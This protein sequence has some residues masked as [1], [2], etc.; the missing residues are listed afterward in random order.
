MINR[1]PRWLLATVV[2]AFS[3]GCTFTDLLGPGMKRPSD[4]P[5]HSKTEPD[6]VDPAP[7]TAQTSND[8]GKPRTASRRQQ[9]MPSPPPMPRRRSSA[10]RIA[11]AGVPPAT[12]SEVTASGPD[13]VLPRAGEGGSKSS[14]GTSMESADEEPSTTDSPLPDVADPIKS[15]DSVDPAPPTAQTSND[16]GK[17]RTASRRQ[18]GIPS[19]PPMPRRRSSGGPKAVA[20]VPPAT[21]SEVTASGPDPVLPRAGEHGG[22]AF[23]DASMGSGDE[24]PRTIVAPSPGVAGPSKSQD[25]GGTECSQR[26]ASLVFDVRKTIRA[27][28][29]EILDIVASRLHAHVRR[30]LNP[31]IQTS[32]G[33]TKDCFADNEIRII[34]QLLTSYLKSLSG[35]YEDAA[36]LYRRTF[37]VSDIVGKLPSAFLRG[38]RLIDQAVRHCASYTKDIIQILRSEILLVGEL[39]FASREVI[40]ALHR[41]YQCPF[42][43]TLLEEFYVTKID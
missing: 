8:P 19:P 18:Q 40:N 12:M 3:F 14:G 39:V 42:V 30:Q 31:S 17:P 7:P 32:I 33:I 29:P 5:S 9:G 2:C 15:P 43:E 23:G 13:P 10:G 6:S 22:K 1:P 35:A 25:A 34:S 24:E 16:P 37:S 36:K 4:T 20:G 27:L 21:I 38:H 41:D 28:A 26:L 11:V